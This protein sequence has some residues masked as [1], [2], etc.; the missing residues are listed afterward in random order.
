[1]TTQP[2]NKD[3]AGRLEVKLEEVVI[4]ASARR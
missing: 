4:S 1:M 3:K 2:E